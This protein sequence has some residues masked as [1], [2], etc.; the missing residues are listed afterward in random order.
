MIY[1]TFMDFVEGGES[2]VQAWF[3][4]LPPS[5]HRAVK[6][7]LN[8]LLLDYRQ[9]KELKPPKFKPLKGVPDIGE[10][11]FTVG[12]VPYRPLYV[13]GPGKD[14]VTILIGAKEVS[15]RFK[16]E[17]RD[18]TAIALVRKALITEPGR[19]REHEYD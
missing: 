6:V 16:F 14:Q 4:S 1:W 5:Q 9:V 18:A 3:A 7:A 11:R 13:K 19:I 8:T 15:T 2:Q 10:I 12:G 17:P